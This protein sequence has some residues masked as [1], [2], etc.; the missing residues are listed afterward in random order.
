MADE[1]KPDTID[2]QTMEQLV[3]A[4]GE[5]ERAEHAALVTRYESAR[6]QVA[7]EPEQMIRLSNQIELQAIGMILI[8]AGVVDLMTYRKIT[9]LHMEKTVETIIQLAMRRQLMNQ[10]LQLPRT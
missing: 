3:E 9:T 6:R 2:F 8:N 10:D 5:V 4:L 1:T 7:T